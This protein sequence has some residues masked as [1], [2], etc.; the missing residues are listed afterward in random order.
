VKA[1]RE[2]R[3]H[4]DWLTPDAGYEGAV[5]SFLDTI[6]QP[7]RPFLEDF[8]RFHAYVAPFGAVGS[9]AQMVVKATC[10]GIPDVYQGT[11]LWD[12]SL[13]DPDNRRPVDFGHRMRLWR[14]LQADDRFAPECLVADL[15]DNW[16]DGR[17]K[18]YSTAKIL[19]YRRSKQALFEAGEYIPLDVRGPAADYVLAYA[20]RY[21]RQWSVTVV[22]RL[23]AALAPA[24]T[25]LR[26]AAEW[27]G[28][29]VLLPD[30]APDCWKHVIASARLRGRYLPLSTVFAPFPIAVL[31]GCRS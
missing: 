25:P 19:R 12:F 22:P 20:R 15:L 10:P 29:A 30:G 7:G 27:R 18:M 28:T 13:V 8:L 23:L 31:D 9:L 16:R 5:L 21:G 4:S 24:C 1:V 2:A 14:D 26:H 11:L 17:I 3:T 6:L